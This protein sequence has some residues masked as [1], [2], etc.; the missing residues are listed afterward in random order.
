MVGIWRSVIGVLAGFT[1]FVSAA[2]GFGGGP[3][4]AATY[5]F[6]YWATPVYPYYCQPGP[7]VLPVPD[8]RST[9]E[10]P[11]QSS[12]GRPK[13]ITSRSLGG[14]ETSTPSKE[15]CRVGFWNLTGRDVTLTVSGKIWPLAKNQAMTVELDRQFTW[16][17]ANRAQHVEQVPDGKMAYEVVVRE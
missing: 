6:Y 13:I 9:M 12:D 16:Q 8:A 1:M 2:A 3:N 7:L 15:R 5:H 11:L 10:P 4:T 17:I 14:T